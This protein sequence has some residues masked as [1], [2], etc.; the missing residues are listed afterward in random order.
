MS[1]YFVF[2]GELIM[3]LNSF[4]KELEH[5]RESQNLSRAALS[6]GICS[7]KQLYR[8]EKSLSEPSIY[9][10]NHLSHRMNRDLFELY[11]IHNIDSNLGFNEI[12]II[13]TYIRDNNYKNLRKFL[14]TIDT[15]S[16]SSNSLFKEH[17][18]YAQSLC[19]YK[20]D[21]DYNS[22]LFYINKGLLLEYKSLNSD[23]SNALFSNCGYCLLNLKASIFLHQN[24]YKKAF[25]LYL[26]IK[27]SLD[28]YF[29]D[30]DCS[31]YLSS[32]FVNKIYT[33]IL[34][35]LVMSSFF[36]NEY[37][38]TIQY[39]DIAI[40]YSMK[41][42]IMRHFQIILEFKA[43]ALYL[44]GHIDESSRLFNAAILLYE[45]DIGY[46]NYIIELKETISTDF[47]LIELF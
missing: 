35:N 26:N 30:M 19:F 13:N 29:V 9:I 20:I 25:T 21:L 46:N 33:A 16:L 38:K 1:M 43:R 23:I 31:S 42:Y 5:L 22:A 15:H 3:S 45:M 36:L 6:D 10:L 7:E 4:G 2:K 24:E 12:N 40:N 17:Y 41:N 28:K 37:D 39:A 8:I 18:Y 27:D 34:S 32:S 11:K 47:P 44:L 14:N